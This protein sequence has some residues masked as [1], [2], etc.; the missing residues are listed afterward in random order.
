MSFHSMQELF[1]RMERDGLPLWEVVLSIDVEDRMVTREESMAKML[2]A[3]QAMQDAADAYTGTRR[4]VSGLVG[5]DGLK[6]RQYAKRG[7]AM[8]GDYISEVIAEALSMAES[9]ACMRRIVAAPTAGSCG[10]LPAVLLPL[11]K[12]EEL[13]QHQILEAL[14]VASGIGSVI[15]HRASISGAEGGCQAEVG[16]AAA[17]AA[18][19]LV[20]LRGGTAAQIGNAV[21]MALKNLMGLACDPVAGL[22]E[23]PCVKRNVI[24]AVD[25]VSAADMALAG[26]ESRIPVDEVIDAM[27]EV[28]RRLPVEL[29]ETALGGLA[30]TPTGRAV[31]KH[32]QGERHAEVLYDPW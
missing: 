29:R 10:V 11:C 1:E 8:S 30:A 32:M 3:W 4:S 5:G 24:G 27:G 20:A 31:K 2:T 6:M 13:T 19:A 21:A 14:Y 7:R 17:M 18:G 15:A 22:V 9:N 28:G 23:V 25:A 26:I 12:R 16:S